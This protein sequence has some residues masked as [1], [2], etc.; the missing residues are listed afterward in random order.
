MAGDVKIEKKLNCQRTTAPKSRLV[1]PNR[2]TFVFNVCEFVVE[3]A[4][5]CPINEWRCELGKDEERGM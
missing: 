5:R 1:I 3:D 4:T 2:N